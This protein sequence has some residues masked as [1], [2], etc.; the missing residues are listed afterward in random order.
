MNQSVEQVLAYCPDEIG[1]AISQLKPQQL[2]RLEE[3]RLRVG[4]PVCVNLAGREWV[5][6]DAGSPIV[7]D[8][9]ML[10]NL[11]GR[12]CAFS[13][14]AVAEQLS[15][16]FL[17]VSG[18][19]RFGVCGTVQPNGTMVQITSVNIRVARQ[20]S[21]FADQV[22]SFVWANPASTLILGPPGC[23]KTTLLREVVRQLSDRFHQ[24]VSVVDE[25]WELAGMAEG[26]PQFYVGRHTDV[27][28]GVGK[29]RGIEMLLR[30]MNPAWIALD[31]ITA[32][33]DVEAVRYAGCCGVRMVATAHADS[34]A[35]L[36]LRP[37][38]RALMELGLFENVIT[39]DA[40]KQTRAE[41]IG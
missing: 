7:A 16:G 29:G 24:R 26:T 14:Y 40:Q 32:R 38:Y 39:M 36:Y 22:M 12:A 6:Q 19:H 31:E 9:T 18:G 1:R 3:I 4:Q 20:I 5:L 33:E 30:G 15:R 34:V 27:L 41:R 23:G 17:T 11:I 25:R 8:L 28:S 13:G 37:V 2:D 35:D 10:K 21:G